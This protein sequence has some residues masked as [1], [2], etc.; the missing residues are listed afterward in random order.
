MRLIDAD[1]LMDK[2]GREKLDTRELILKMIEDAPTW[3]TKPIWQDGY[4]Q[5]VKDKEIIEKNLKSAWD[6]EKNLNMQICGRLDMQEQV[7]KMFIR[8]FI[9]ALRNGN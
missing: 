6:D 7:I 5:A 3:D 8:E 2:A 4:N 1:T 9:Y